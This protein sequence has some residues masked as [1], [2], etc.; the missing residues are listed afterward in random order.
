MVRKGFTLIETLISLF[1]SLLLFLSALEFFDLS[2]NIFFKLKDEEEKMESALSALDKM[3]IDFLHAGLGLFWPLNL[4]L[5]EA[6]AATENG[7]S[8][9]RGKEKL[10]LKKD[11]CPGDNALFLATTTELIK[12]QEICLGDEKKGE[13]KTISAVSSDR[14]TLSSPLN[15]SYSKD[16]TW[17]IALEKIFYYF[18]QNN[19]ILRRKVGLSPAQPLVEEV[20]QVA[21]NYDKVSNLI[22][23]SFILKA[24]EEKKYEIIVFPKNTALLF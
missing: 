19:K 9:L 1:L 21:F 7:L 15:F 11:V 12:G 24:K 4:G 10:H 16:D 5:L 17:I 20:S 14:I 6:I 13:I 8:I 18:D 23:A 3:K 2:R 22:K